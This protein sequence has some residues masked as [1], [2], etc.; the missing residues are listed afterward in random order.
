MGIKE[1]VKHKSRPRQKIR[2]DQ[3]PSEVKVR[4]GKI[5]KKASCADNILYKKNI[6][7]LRS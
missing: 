3:N 2:P 7:K 4:M 6:K 1:T 5:R